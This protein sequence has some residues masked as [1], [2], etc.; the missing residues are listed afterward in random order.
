MSSDAPDTM[1]TAQLIDVYPDGWESILLEGMAITRFR[2]G[3][4][5]AKKM[6]KGEVVKLSLYLSM[7]SKSS[8]TR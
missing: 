8:R 1:F 6:K 5:K 2:D 4:E 3:M 7:I